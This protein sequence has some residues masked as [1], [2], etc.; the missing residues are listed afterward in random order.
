VQ[1]VRGPKKFGGGVSPPKIHDM[2][3]RRKAQ[4]TGERH[5]KKASTHTSKECFGSGTFPKEYQVEPNKPAKSA[6]R[7]TDVGG[8]KGLAKEEA[9]GSRLVARRSQKKN[10]GPHA[11][12][13]KK[14]TR[15][16]EERPT[17]KKA[18]KEWIGKK[19][20][21]QQ[22]T[23]GTAESGTHVRADRGKDGK[24]KR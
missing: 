16:P 21:C 11:H 4:K 22:H 15:R 17:H 13:T 2:K 8:H 9:G 20:S 6:P 18:K 7:L 3:E 1:V 12:S 14:G 24:K 5:K 23:S 10:N 19:K